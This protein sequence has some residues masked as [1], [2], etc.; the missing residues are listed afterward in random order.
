MLA[1]ALLYVGAEL[2][3][4]GDDLVPVGGGAQLAAHAAV[5]PRGEDAVHLLVEGFVE[6]ADGLVPHLLPVGNLVEVLLHVGREVVVHD[7]AE[8]L[9]EVVRDDDADLLREELA[10]LRAHGLG[11]GFLR[12]RPVLQVEV[13]HRHLHAVLVALGDIA[14]G[15]GE[16]ADDGGVG[17]RTADFQLFQ[18]L[19]EGGLGIALR[20]NGVLALGGD[21]L[22]LHLVADMELR[23]DQVALFGLPR[24]CRRCGRR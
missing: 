6:G 1:F 19:D 13:R 9:D 18:L 7:F 3:E 11:P 2:A 16:G 17:G 8:I 14:A 22:L 4:G 15:G 21:A 23:Q 12:D 10:A 24:G 20:R 5:F